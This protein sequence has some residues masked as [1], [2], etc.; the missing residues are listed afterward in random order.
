[1]A[2]ESIS[3]HAREIELQTSV[4][5]LD[6]VK[7]AAYRLLDRCTI[8]ISQD[9]QT[10]KCAFLFSGGASQAAADAAIR[11]FRAELLDQD[12]RKKISDETAPLRNAILALAFAPLTQKT[13]E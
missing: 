6:T 7:R 1:M 2:Q 12:L 5:D 4:Y 9:G 3:A 13:R 10:I 8:D 11:D